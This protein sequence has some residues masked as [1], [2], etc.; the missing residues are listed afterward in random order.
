MSS[1]LQRLDG[2]ISPSQLLSA[3]GKFL[4]VH[5]PQERGVLKL[6]YE[7]RTPVCIPAF[8]DSEL[9]NDVFCHNAQR[10]GRGGR[11]KSIID[12]ERDSRLLMDLA[13]KSKKMGIFS[14]GGGVPGNNTRNVASLID[15]YGKRLELPNHRSVR[16]YSYSCKICPDPMWL[17]HYSGCTG[18][19]MISWN[20]AWPDAQLCDVHADATIAWPLILKWAME[21]R[22]H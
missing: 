17:G 19:E 13:R 8:V 18:S 9:G 22:G 2:V 7:H 14:I 16:K 4:S 20:K 1:V 3:V 21:N 12:M 10:G 6:A 15:I 5:Y 11:P